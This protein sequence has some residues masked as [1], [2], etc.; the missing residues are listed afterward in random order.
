L[1]TTPAHALINDNL[2]T[3]YQFIG[4]NTTI[5]WI[6]CGATQ[7]TSGCFDA[8]QLSGFGKVCAILEGA[9]GI[10]GNTVTQRVG[11]LDGSYK[12]TSS[13]VLDVYKKIGQLSS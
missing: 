1:A 8:G 11:V 10:V 3:T 12:S 5:S 2:Y 7:Q 4:N 9:P 6:T 13:V